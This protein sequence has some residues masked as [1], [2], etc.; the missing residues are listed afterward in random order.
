MDQ[1]K[2]KL[3]HRLEAGTGISTWEDLLFKHLSIDRPT[4]FVLGGD[5]TH[6]PNWANGYVKLVK[7]LIAGFEKDADI[8][9]IYYDSDT[10]INK[11]NID[12]S[13]IV[14]SLL[15]TLIAFKDEEIDFERTLKNFRRVNFFTHCYGDVV[16]ENISQQLYER[17]LE[18]GLSEKDSRLL[19]EQMLI[20]SYGIVSFQPFMKSIN[21]ISPYDK[22]FNEIS[23]QYWKFLLSYLDK[24][25]SIAMSE[26]DKKVLKSIKADSEKGNHEL[27]SKRLRE[28][29]SMNQRCFVIQDRNDIMLAVSALLNQN[30]DYESESKA[31]E[32]VIHNIRREEGWKINS[33]A[34]TAS[35]YL[36]LILGGALK[37]SI[38]NSRRNDTQAEFEPIDMTEYAGTF[39]DVL[40]K[41]NHTKTKMSNS[42][43]YSDAG[44]KEQQ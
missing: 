33:K 10:S 17:L 27:V 25:D 42:V 22:L 18:I 40:Y 41:L 29:Y 32:H 15:N 20:I 16:S 9:A 43:N 2:F 26:D 30:L 1:V 44:V 14:E 28:F 39:N 38:E 3:G 21:V 24:M 37:M 35:K 23:D 8:Y 11:R 5:W 6:D 31:D 4:I 19:L 36:S 7:G 12:T 34:S 13:E